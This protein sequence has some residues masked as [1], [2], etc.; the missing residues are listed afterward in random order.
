MN[1]HA[2][3]MTGAEII[4]VNRSQDECARQVR[5]AYN[6]ILRNDTHEAREEMLKSLLAWRDAVLAND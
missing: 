4:A 6:N 5:R 2:I 1:P 3:G